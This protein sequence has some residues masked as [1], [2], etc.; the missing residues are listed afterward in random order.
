ML[1]TT[2]WYTCLT[3]K[4]CTFKKFLRIYFIYLLMILCYGGVC[5][6]L[7]SFM[8][9]QSHIVLVVSNALVFVAICFVSKWLSRKKRIENFCHELK[10]KHGAKIVDCKAFLDSGNLLV[11]PVTDRP[12][13]LLNFKIFSKLFGE[14]VDLESVLKGLGQKGAMLAHYISFNT[15]NKSDKI[16]VFQVDE[17]RIDGKTEKNAMFGLSFKNFNQAFGSDVILNNAFA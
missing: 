14:D 15:L 8:L 9:V 4:F 11:D 10:I 17:I 13:N 12:V 5:Y 1:G 2:I 7:S 6:F 3:F 16:L